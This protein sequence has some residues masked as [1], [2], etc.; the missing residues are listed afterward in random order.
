[1][2]ATGQPRAASG[3]QAAA[4]PVSRRTRREHSQEL[5]Q[6]YVEIISDLVAATGE[7]RAIDL[8]RRLGVSHVTVARA[9]HRLQRDGLVTA[10]PYRS[11]FLTEAGRKL[12]EESRRRHQ[13]VLDFLLALGVP[14]PVAQSDTEGIEHHVSKDTLAAFC[15][16]L[17]RP[18]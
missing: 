8:A 17:K 3:P 14:P 6:D 15:R 12:A 18:V 16:H 9:V 7:A 11:I 4:E 2:K 5:A 10:Q 13:I 1:M